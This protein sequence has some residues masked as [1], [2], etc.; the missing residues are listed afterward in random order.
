MLKLRTITKQKLDVTSPPLK[1]ILV[2][3]DMLVVLRDESAYQNISLFNEMS[4]LHRSADSITNLAKNL[5]VFASTT[6]LSQVESLVRKANDYHHLRALF[7]RQDVNCNWLP[8]MLY[9]SNVK[10]LKNMIVYSDYKIPQRILTAWKL[11]AQ[12]QLIADAI[13][14]DDKLSVM[15]CALE[16]YDVF[17]SK[18]PAMNKIPINERNSFEIV[19]DGSYIYWPNSDVHIDL[20]SIRCAIDETW[21]ARFVALRLVQ[22]NNYGKAIAALRKK[23]KLRQADVKGLSERQLRRIETGEPTSVN[24]L[25]LLAKAHSMELSDYLDKLALLLQEEHI[26]KT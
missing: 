18:I 17:F 13:Y 15:S 2:H 5:F 24:T 12:N 3:P 9:Q 7:I 6:Q 10:A 19:P 20:D 25:K 16:K 14:F 26:S 8:Q 22:N 1:T 11:G 23:L 4:V 21:K